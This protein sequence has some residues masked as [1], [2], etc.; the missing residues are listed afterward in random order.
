MNIKDLRKRV[1]LMKNYKEE[2]KINLDNE[3]QLKDLRK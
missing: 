1:D 3:Q 2:T